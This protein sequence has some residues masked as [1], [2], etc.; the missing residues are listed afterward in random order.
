MIKTRVLLKGYAASAE[1]TRA[2]LPEV[3]TR[4]P[5][6]VEENVNHYQQVNV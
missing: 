3:L 4:L 5:T 6:C 1:K 2:D